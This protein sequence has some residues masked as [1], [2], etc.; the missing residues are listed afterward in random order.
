MPGLSQDEGL[1]LILCR[2]FHQLTHLRRHSPQKSQAWCSKLD[3]LSGATLPCHWNDY[4]AG[5]ANPATRSGGF[6]DGNHGNDRHGEL[7]VDEVR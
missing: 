1:I 7:V 5:A 6:V 4:R 3:S 2:V